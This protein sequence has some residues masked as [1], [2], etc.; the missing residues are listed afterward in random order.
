M[1]RHRFVPIII[2]CACAAGICPAEE[3]GPPVTGILGAFGMEMDLVAEE[4]VNPERHTHLGM[5]FVTGT[6]AG[7]TVALSLTGVGK[8][9]AAMTATLLIDHFH[10]SEVIF[11]GIAGGL[12]PDLLPGDIVIGAKTAQHDYGTWTADG[13]VIRAAR[14]PVDGVRNPVYFR[15]DERL[16]RLARQAADQ[17]ELKSIQTLKG[18]HAPKI[19]QGTIIT[20]DI[21]V[22]STPKKEE[23]R[24][25]LQADAVEMEGAA[26]AQVCY[27]H[28]V[29]CLVVRSLSDTADENAVIDSQRFQRI[30]AA[31]SAK[32]VMAIA[33]LL[34]QE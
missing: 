8:V 2:M 31:N 4:I 29:P 6:L 16:L 18:E 34:G 1:R 17:T 26:V 11:T 23:L 10:P 27:Q 22:A 30:A 3:A 33:G 28:G 25:L 5:A 7:R 21:F 19:L 9:N 15:G 14:N 32:L 24:D 12:N 13:I 20:G